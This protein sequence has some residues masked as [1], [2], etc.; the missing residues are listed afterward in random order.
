[1]TAFIPFKNIENRYLQVFEDS[2]YLVYFLVLTFPVSMCCVLYP[3]ARCD[4]VNFFYENRSCLHAF[5]FNYSSI[6]NVSHFLDLILSF[7]QCSGNSFS[8]HLHFILFLV[9]RWEVETL[10][11]FGSLSEIC[12]EVVVA[13]LEI[14]PRS[15]VYEEYCISLGINQ[16]SPLF[17]H[18]QVFFYR[19]MLT[20]ELESQVELF[21]VNIQKLQ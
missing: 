17:L 1:M 16:K 18:F 5:M 7:L 4:V 10:M 15:A 12:R 19:F 20:H 11:V 2:C 9:G 21:V 8:E 14:C 13:W 6:T 3:V